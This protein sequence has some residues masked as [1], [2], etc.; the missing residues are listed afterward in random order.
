LK[1]GNTLKAMALSALLFLIPALYRRNRN[2]EKLMWRYE[3]KTIDA[4]FNSCYSN[5]RPKNRRIKTMKVLVDL[6]GRACYTNIVVVGKRHAF[7][8]GFT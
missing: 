1:S 2:E 7:P 3:T 8:N 4:A 5:K 6:D